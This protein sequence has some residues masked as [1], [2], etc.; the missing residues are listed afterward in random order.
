MA[1]IAM[2]VGEGFEDSEFREPCERLKEV[3][4]E[5]VTIGA[6]RGERLW[7]KR[8]E[9]M[10]TIDAIPDDVDPAQFDALVIPGGHSPDQLRTN[11]GI[12]S[13][14]RRFCDSGKLV[15]A[16]CHGPQLLIEA[17]AVAGRELTSWPSIRKDLENAD[18]HW[19]DREVV[20]DGNLITSR[21]PDDLDAFCEA[22]LERLPLRIGQAHA[23]APIG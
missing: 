19:V 6:E 21:G 9:T 3:G 16:I 1:K 12:V 14:V 8:G 4:H 11:Q 20:E 23:S 5:V 7:G 18:A 10:A 17:D 13:F 22:I 15:A 2:P